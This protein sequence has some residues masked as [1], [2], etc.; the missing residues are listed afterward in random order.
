LIATE[1][2]DAKCQFTGQVKFGSAKGG[3][4]RNRLDAR[5][6]VGGAINIGGKYFWAPKVRAAN[7]GTS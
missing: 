2:N 3:K 6:G 5:H 1:L 7:L 4:S